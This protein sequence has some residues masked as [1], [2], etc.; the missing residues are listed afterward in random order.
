MRLQ[1]ALALIAATAAPAAAVAIEAAPP[2]P[3]LDASRAPSAIG[4]TA[5]IWDTTCWASLGGAGASTL[6]P[7]VNFTAGS[8]NL[9]DYSSV[10]FIG[11]I[12]P[13]SGNATAANFTVASDG[14]VRLWVDDHLLI[15]VQAPSTSAVATVA[16]EA[17]RFRG[18]APVKFRLDYAHYTG[19]RPSLV[20]SWALAGR[21]GVAVVPS[22]AFT[23]NVAPAEATR[24]RLR[25]RQYSPRQPWQT[26]FYSSMGAHVLMPSGFAVDVTLGDLTTGALLGNLQLFRQS[27]PAIVAVG[28]HSPNGSDY[29]RLSIDRWLNASC[30]VVLESTVMPSRDASPTPSLGIVATSVGSACAHLALVVRPKFVWGYAGNA[31]VVNAAAFAASVPGRMFGPVVVQSADGAASVAFPGAGP[32]YIALQL[33][34]QGASGS[35]V[36]G[37]A[38]GAAPRTVAEIQAAASVARAATLARRD[39]FGAGDLADV[40]D[41]L[42]AVIQWNTIYTPVRCREVQVVGAWG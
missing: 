29:S 13:P 37:V 42:D 5:T 19:V 39:R 25:D 9:S 28:A 7:N 18:A 30:A 11:T 35:A 1:Y 33:A 2:P 21:P 38:T 41:S 40:W 27:S 24:Q 10:R 8:Y 6:A 23:P 3:A 34:P 22:S 14:I 15:D 20:L 17:Y 36:V 26:Y 32:V 31:S 12:A 4:L 16:V